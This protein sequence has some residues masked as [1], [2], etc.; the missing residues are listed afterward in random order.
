MA[1]AFVQIESIEPETDTG[2]LTLN[3][4]ILFHLGGTFDKTTNQVSIIAGDTLADIKARVV[5]AIT[6]E[7]TRLGYSVP[8]TNMILPAFQRGS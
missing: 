8:T 1:M 2:Y 7:A 3:L 6:A 4:E 5:S